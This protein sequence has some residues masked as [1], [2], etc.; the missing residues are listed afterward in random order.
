VELTCEKYKE[1]LKNGEAIC[2]HP[3]EYCKFRE[4]CIIN[5]MTR[6]LAREKKQTRAASKDAEGSKQAPEKNEE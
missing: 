4:A 2:S 1:K 3:E 6:E 5:F